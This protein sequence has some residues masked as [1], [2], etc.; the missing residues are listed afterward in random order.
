MQEVYAF[1]ELFRPAGALG[2]GVCQHVFAEK[3]PERNDARE[4]VELAEQKV[5]S[6][7]ETLR[8]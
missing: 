4:R 7:V 1:V 3:H 2:Q 8:V 5:V 6:I